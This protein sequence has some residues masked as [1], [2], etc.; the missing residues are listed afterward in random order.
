MDDIICITP[1]ELEKMTS[2]IKCTHYGL[3]VVEID[4]MEFA[5][6]ANEEEADK[7]CYEYIENTIW[8]FSPFF[9]E[10]MT[11]VPAELFEAVQ[12][13][14]ESIN[15]A[16]QILVMRTCGM[17]EFVDQAISW[18]GRG[19]FLSHYDGKEIELNCGAYAYRVN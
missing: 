11:N 6:A 16:L 8:A 9:L 10:Q 12:D 18:D 1:E 4:G 5:I 14:C 3:P 7:A 17:Q 2:G 19:H 15:E 13:K